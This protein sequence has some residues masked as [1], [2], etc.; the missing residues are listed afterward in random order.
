[1]SGFEIAGIVLAGVPLLLE[2]FKGW[3][4]IGKRWK[5]WAHIKKE[6]DSYRADIEF[7]DV[8]LTDNLRELLFP[9]LQDEAKV[10]ELTAN[11]ELLFLILQDEDKVT[12]LMA[13]RELLFSILQDE[14]K[15]N[16]LMAN[17]EDKDQSFSALEN[18]LK[19]RLRGRYKIYR[20]TVKSLCNTLEDFREELNM[21]IKSPANKD[22]MS[23]WE[24][25]QNLL[26]RITSKEEREYQ[27]CRWKFANGE[28]RRRSLMG[29]IETYF[30]RLNQLLESS[31]K[32]AAMMQEYALA[33]VTRAIDN[34]SLNFWRRATTL[35]DAL[36][37]SW[38]CPCVDQHCAKLILE[39]RGANNS[40]L[41]IMFTKE[42]EVGLDVV[43]TRITSQNRDKRRATKRP[44]PDILVRPTKP[45]HREKI[46]IRSAFKTTRSTSTS[47]QVVAPYPEIRIEYDSATFQVDNPTPISCLCSSLGHSTEAGNEAFCGYL[48]DDGGRYFYI[49]TTSQSISDSLT[50]VPF[51]CILQDSTMPNMRQ[52]YS[53]AFTIASSVLQLLES[54]WLPNFHSRSEILFF[55]RSKPASPTCPHISRGF[56]SREQDRIC[57]SDS[58]VLLGI[59]L[60]ELFFG[61]PISS[62]DFRKKF[63]PGD[64]RQELLFDQA[65]GIQWL[66]ELKDNAAPLEYKDA[67]KWCLMEHKPL[68]EEPEAWRREMAIRVVQ[69][70]EKCEDWLN[71]G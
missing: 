32:E 6:F 8:A 60:L 5:L 68:S 30:T 16:E 50:A 29:L 44:E 9:I 17:P 49:Y 47:V 39:H 1:M 51:S 24:A 20:S 34:A 52:R 54:P 25:A 21:D 48:C 4:E 58:L 43:E 22:S 37:G 36:A 11:R 27:W 56:G 62:K 35:F 71:R 57:V 2:A 12:E 38:N 41:A 42:R 31:E 19:D 15:V 14:A 46:P 55:L 53:L 3:E 23:R 70:L 18:S 59:V 61:E 65:V 33:Q 67:V 13:D 10:N 63:P 64:K 40:D 7:Y 66:D 26:R 28:A 45:R 69:N